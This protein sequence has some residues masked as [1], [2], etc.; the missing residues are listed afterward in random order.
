MEVHHHHQGSYAQGVIPVKKWNTRLLLIVFIFFI[1]P[2]YSISQQ[3]I[4]QARLNQIAQAGKLWGYI[5]YHHPYLQYRNI[6]W[7]SSFAAI[8]PD[9]LSSQ[10]EEEYEKCISKLLGVIN[11]PVTSVIH[12]KPL[13]TAIKYPEPTIIDSIMVITIQDYRTILKRDSLIA[14]FSTAIKKLGQA[15]AVIFDL[16]PD[17][18]T[19]LLNDEISLQE[20]FDESGILRNV[21]RGTIALPAII[22]VAT[23]ENSIKRFKTETPENNS[24]Y[25]SDFS[26]DRRRSFTGIS[27]RDIPV[28]FINNKYSELPIE[29]LALQSAGKAALIQEEGTGEIGVVPVEKFYITNNIAIRLRAG[30]IIN[31]TSTGYRASLIIPADDNRE[32]A[33]TKAKEIIKIGNYTP[34]NVPGDFMG[35]NSNLE[36]R[37]LTKNSYP[38]VGDRVLAA[39]KIYSVLKFYYPNKHLWTHNWDSVYL[40]FLPRF[41]AARDSIE[42]IRTIMEMYAHVQDGHGVMNHP[43][44]PVIRGITT[45]DFSPPPFRTRIIEGQLVVTDIINDSITKALDIKPGDII[46]EKNGLDVSKDLDER[47][48]YFSASNYDAQSGYIT[49]TYLT[50]LPGTV[51]KLKLKDE[52]GKI[53]NIDLPFYKPT[54]KENQRR[55][56]FG[57]KGNDKPVMY[58]IKKEIGYVNLGALVPGQVDSMF[59]MFKEAK[60]IIFDARAYPRGGPIYTI[61]PRL[62]AKR[63][64]VNR[65][66]RMLPGW[67]M[68]DE[69]NRIN[70]KEK[71]TGQIVALI[72]ENTQSHGEVT[73]DIL[74]LSGTL[75]GNHTAGAN[76]DVVSFFVPGDMRLTFS[77]GAAWMQGK[78][79]QPDILVTPTIKGIRNGKDE[80][81]E[82]AVRFVETGN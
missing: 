21:F 51:V 27:R 16:R 44:V 14:I 34:M 31:N 57:T 41:I 58:F 23:P 48:K 46:L 35:F 38:S 13:N 53:K 50:L 12:Y 5:K 68:D 62:I 24:N 52:S 59:T 18:N 36:N 8:V 74:S 49:A 6:P 10:N 33:I 2:T 56:D 54:E 82:R 47:R 37:T 28:I 65:K 64:S 63:K 17:K 60:A 30:E 32:F 26:V 25:Q 42:Y 72:H 20:I 79:I 69:W 71:Y 75:I 22:K 15:K 78:G 76:G 43:L 11:D 7:D 67:E 55:R 3:S 4:E 29:A 45:R 81:L 66:I 39:A 73:A 70:K 61:Y 80:I 1:S 77:G 9:I 19:F 40:H